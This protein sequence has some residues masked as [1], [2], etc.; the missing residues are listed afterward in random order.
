MTYPMMHLMLLPPSPE[1]TPVKTTFFQK[2]VDGNNC[3]TVSKDEQFM[4]TTDSKGMLG[5]R[6]GLFFFRVL[7]I[8]TNMG[9]PYELRSESP[10]CPG[11]KSL[12]AISSDGLT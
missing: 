6:T 9:Q 10:L 4:S 7:N 3:I 8:Q 5:N 11:R 1:Q 12:T 2:Y